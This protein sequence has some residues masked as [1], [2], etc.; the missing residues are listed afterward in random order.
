MSLLLLILV[1][2]SS[3]QLLPES[4]HQCLSTC[5]GG[6]SLELRSRDRRQ[7]ELFFSTRKSYGLDLTESSNLNIAL[8]DKLGTNH[9]DQDRGTHKRLSSPVPV[10]AK[11]TAA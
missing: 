3:S 7:L 9:K 4:C 2:C 8:L 6:I 1:C 5:C 10:P 11:P